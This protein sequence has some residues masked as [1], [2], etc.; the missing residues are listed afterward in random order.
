M[1]QPELV[2]ALRVAPEDGG[3]SRFPNVVGF[4]SL[5]WWTL[6]SI[7]VMNV[8]YNII[9]SI[10]HFFSVCCWD[11]K[12]IHLSWKQRAG[13][14]R[15]RGT[16][17]EKIENELM[18]WNIVWCSRGVTF[19]MAVM[20]MCITVTNW[21]VVHYSQYCM[22][23]PI[24]STLWRWV[25]NFIPQRLYLWG[26]SPGTHCIGGWEGHRTRGSHFD[27]SVNLVSNKSILVYIFQPGN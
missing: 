8:P 13:R 22:P 5:R 6:S 7:L 21:Q 4:F 24:I 17:M 20:L 9:K 2:P 19:L 14:L 1:D 25:V 16:R 11:E 3:R 18:G 26:Q 12:W 27:N 10:E 23:L 15:D